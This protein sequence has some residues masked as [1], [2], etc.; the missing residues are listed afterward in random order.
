MIILF[1]DLVGDFMSLRGAPA[2]SSLFYPG[3]MVFPNVASHDWYDNNLFWNLVIF[4]LSLFILVVLTISLP[5]PCGFL[6]LVYGA[7]AAVGRIMGE[8][9]GHDLSRNPHFFLFFIKKMSS[10]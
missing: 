3:P 9:V 8:W 6:L 1:P 10:G 5:I 4:G 2:L 7:G